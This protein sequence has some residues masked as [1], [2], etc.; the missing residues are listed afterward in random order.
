[1]GCDGIWETM[2]NEEVAKYIKKK[3]EENLDKK[4][5]LSNFLDDNLA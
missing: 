5:I 2:T 4:S 3:L 1:M